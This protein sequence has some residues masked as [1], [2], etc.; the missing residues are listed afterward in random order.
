MPEFNVANHPDSKIFVLD[1]NP[2]NV[3]F[4]EKLLA[5]AGYTNVKSSTNPTEAESICRFYK[6]DLVILDL[7]MP[8]MSGYEV[9]EMLRS[10]STASGHLPILVFTA[11][12]TG[13]ARRRALELGATDFLTKPGDACEITL[14]VRNFLEMSHLYRELEDQNYVLEERVHERTRSLEQAQLEIVHR[15]AL[16]CDYRDDDT[17]EHCRRVGELSYSIALEYG[18]SEQDARLIGLAAPLHDIGKVAVP[19][20]I[21]RKPDKL[22][23]SE[24]AEIRK[25]TDLGASIL[26]HSRSEILQMAH[27]IALTHH[28]RWDG[29][30]YGSGLVGEAIPIAGRIVSVADVYDVLTNVRPYKR[31]WEPEAAIAEIER[32]SGSQFDPTVVE[33]FLRATRR[34]RCEEQTNVA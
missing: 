29:K 7:H 28:E 13:D 31:A 6:P 20:A 33:A 1:D 14:R 23:D 9:L 16:A 17:G 10:D 25:H 26:A 30:G 32:C 8:G 24:F 15:L 5:K 2:M 21:L 27:T 18:L 12:A 34:S 4:L 19:D 22:N 3:L 11:D